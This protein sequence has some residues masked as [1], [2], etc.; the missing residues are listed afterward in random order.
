MF[1][2]V[3]ISPETGEIYNATIDLKIDV[4]LNSARIPRM[5]G[6]LKGALRSGDS[7]VAPGAVPKPSQPPPPLDP[8]DKRRE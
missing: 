7:L 2:R 5:T 8:A 4:D 1:G 6:H 3:E